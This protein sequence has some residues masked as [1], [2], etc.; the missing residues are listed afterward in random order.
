V[1]LAC[2]LTAT[3]ARAALAASPRDEL[4][5]YVPPDIGFCLALQDLRSHATMLAD[6]PFLDQLRDSPL[7]VQLRKAREWAR[8]MGM[9]AKLRKQ[10]GVDWAKIHDDIL[11]DAVVFAYRGN[12]RDREQGLILVRARTA[13]ALADFVERLNKAQK[14]LGELKELQPKEHKGM[15]Y[16]RRVEAKGANYYALRGAVLVCSS[17]EAIVQE[18]LEQ[19]AATEAEPPLAARF[20]DGAADK[21]LLAVYLNPR[22]LDA[23]IEQGAADR[24]AAKTFAVCWKAIDSIVWS[25]HL[26]RDLRVMLALRGRPAAM[27]DPVRRFLVEAA[28]ASDLWRLFPE[29]AFFAMVLRIPVPEFFDAIAAF[30]PQKDRQAMPEG[31]ERNL[32]TLLGKDFYKEVL[33]AIGPDAGLCILPPASS[34][35]NWFPQALLVVRASQGVPGGG[36]DQA[37]LGVVYSGAFWALIAYNHEHPDKPVALRTTV[38]DRQEVKYLSGDR[39]FPPGV[40]P[41]LALREGHLVLASSLEA[42]RRFRPADGPA[43]SSAGI[44]LWRISFTACRTYLAERRKELSAAVAEK[45]GIPAEEAGKRLDT[46]VAGLQFLDRADLRLQAST[47]QALFTLR[48]QPSQPLKK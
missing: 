42:L 39:V 10:L 2:L 35:R 23:E 28:R 25:L 47:G 36:I 27:P 5:R 11:G 6:S 13:E 9:E 4:L 3:V 20:R 24:E 14:E 44:L 8:L 38:I 18:A 30:L 21:A 32:G 41:A 34:D 7:G 22:S 17:D 16:F 45:D 15:Q 26:D 43:D 1:A 48:V 40:Q 31:W 29:N 33:P 12:K 37:L 46:L 19:A